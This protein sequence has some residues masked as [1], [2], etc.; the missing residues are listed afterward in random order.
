MRQAFAIWGC[1]G[2]LACLACLF[3]TTASLFAIQAL[4]VWIGGTVLFGFGTIITKN[5]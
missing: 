1:V 3:L 2:L 5:D 4:L